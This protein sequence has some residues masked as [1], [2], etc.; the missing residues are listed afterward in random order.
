TEANPPARLIDAVARGDVDIAVAWGPLAGYFAMHE[1]ARLDVVPV[2]PVVDG[3]GVSFAFDIAM[4]VAKGDTTLRNAL[5]GVL[6]RERAPIQ[7]LLRDYGTPLLPLPSLGPAD[8][9]SRHAIPAVPAPLNSG[10]QSTMPARRH[11]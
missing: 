1:N 6:L 11:E 7:R 10:E 3:L 4:G 9:P 8:T 2:S 5:D